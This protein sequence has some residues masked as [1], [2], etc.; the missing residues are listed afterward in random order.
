MA[1][2]D[3]DNLKWI[4]ILLREACNTIAKVRKEFISYKMLSIHTKK[5]QSIQISAQKNKLRY[6]LAQE[7]EH[8]VKTYKKLTKRS[9][10]K[11]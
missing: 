1:Y 8:E 5:W 4:P 7:H 11:C 9:K 2:I 6:F 10:Y 3:L